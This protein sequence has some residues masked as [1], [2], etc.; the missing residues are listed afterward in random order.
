[1][2]WYDY[3]LNAVA[4]EP[5]TAFMAAPIVPLI[6]VLVAMDFDPLRAL[7]AV[8]FCIPYAYFTYVAHKEDRHVWWF[9]ALA[10][11]LLMG[12]CMGMPIA[13]AIIAEGE[14]PHSV[15][16][17]SRVP[18]YL[19]FVLGLALWRLALPKPIV[20]ARVALLAVWCALPFFVFSDRETTQFAI[21]VSI[22]GMYN[23]SGGTR[24][25]H[26]AELSKV[27]KFVTFPT[28]LIAV[29]LMLVGIVDLAIGQPLFEYTQMQIVS[30]VIG[31]LAL[32]IGAEIWELKV[33]STAEWL[34]GLLLP[35]FGLFVVIQLF[36]A[37]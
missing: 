34:Q 11:S 7:G 35:A 28:T 12:A 18:M 21:M 33:R 5:K 26:L 31:T 17:L 37:A 20:F 15:S 22:Y 36:F 19:S 27:F 14:G 8:I 29:I 4:Y 16:G 1:M 30:I 13:L 23:L 25:Q 2:K 10:G 32:F 6:L 24:D 9:Q 3:P